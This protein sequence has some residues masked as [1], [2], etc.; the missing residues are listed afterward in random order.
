MK[1]TKYL[2]VAAISSLAFTACGSKDKAGDTDT[3]IESSAALIEEEVVDTVVKTDTVTKSI[4]TSIP[5]DTTGFKTTASG[6]KYKII[7]P[8][9]GTSPK[10]TDE[11]TVNYIGQLPNGTVFDSS[12]ERGEA[13][14][15]PLSGV[16]KGW[17]EGLQLM[18]PGSTAI[19]YI[20]AN[21]GYGAQGAGPIP[22]NSPLFFQVDLISVN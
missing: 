22:P 19:F 21:L 5:T 8:G 13:A 11:V 18:K 2:M 17:T 6:L 12:Y 14:T 15:F 16:I 20:P 3:V 1:I 7:K 9:Q 4:P 10:A